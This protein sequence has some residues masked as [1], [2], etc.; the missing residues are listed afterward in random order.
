MFTWFADRLLYFPSRCS[1]VKMLTLCYVLRFSSFF[2]VFLCFRGWGV[3]VLDVTRPCNE[4]W[5]WKNGSAWEPL[6]IRVCH[7]MVA[8][9]DYRRESSTVVHLFGTGKTVMGFRLL[10]DGHNL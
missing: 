7:Q 4:T 1:H 6:P 9:R 2:S 3:G 8:S 10:S 5:L